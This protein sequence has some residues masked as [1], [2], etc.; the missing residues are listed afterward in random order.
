[1]VLADVSKQFQHTSYA[2]KFPAKCSRSNLYVKFFYFHSSR[3]KKYFFLHHPVILYMITHIQD[4][5]RKL[6]APIVESCCWMND[7]M[8]VNFFP[9]GIHTTEFSSL[10]WRHFYFQQISAK[11]A[12]G[13]NA[14]GKGTNSNNVLHPQSKVKKFQ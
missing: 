14:H 6:K 4:H 7:V 5:N 10:H 11:N 12:I 9:E 13:F 8:R 3:V 1:M 2:L